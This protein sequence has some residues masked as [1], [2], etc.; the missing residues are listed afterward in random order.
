MD[1]LQKFSYE[2]SQ[3]RVVT[4]D[5]QPWFVGKDVT[6]ILGFTNGRKA[7]EDHVDTEDRQILQKSP[8]VTFEIP[9]RG[10]TIIN[11]SGI[12]SLTFSSRL[13]SAK[14]F[15]R[16]VTSEVLPSIRKHGAY[17]TPETMERVMDD[18]DF[19]IGLVQA[20][21]EERAKRFALE[22]EKQALL[23]KAEYCDA[24][25]RSPSLIPTNVI[26]KDYGM[27][28]VRFN[29]MLENMGIQYKRGNMWALKSQYQD[30]GYTQS[31]TF[32]R[33]GSLNTYCWNKWTETG[34]QFLYDTLK[35]HDILP[36]SERPRKNSHLL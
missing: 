22:A 10:Y 18:P 17:L 26:A 16:W 2:N 24:V 23:P 7:I 27:S 4:K 8:D 14:Q 20:L 32:Q 11:E 34:R 5:G 3:V 1:T 15:K 6:D 29:R 25:L 33:E 13:P 21:K 12:Y 30:K 28:A 9:P 35:A 36:M 19:I 31:E